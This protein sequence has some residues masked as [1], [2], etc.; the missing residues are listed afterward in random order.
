MSNSL[1][2]SF[3]LPTYNASATL[4]YTA[5]IF[6]ELTDILVSPGRRDPKSMLVT[7]HAGTANMTVD[8]SAGGA[9]VGGSTEGAQDASGMWPQGVYGA[10]L[11][12]PCTVIIPAAPGTG[13][14]VDG[15]YLQ[16]AD[17]TETGSGN[18]EAII[19]V[20][21]PLTTLP[22]SS[23]LLAMVSVSAGTTQ[24][25]NSAIAPQTNYAASPTSHLVGEI[26]MKAGVSIPTGFLACDG[27][28]V[29]RSSFPA[30]FSEIGI[31][32]GIGDGTT[33]FNLPNLNSSFMFPLGSITPGVQGGASAHTH[34]GPSHV[35]QLNGT[36]YALVTVNA[37]GGPQIQI[38]RKS[39]VSWV[40]NEGDS[41]ATA[42]SAGATGQTTGAD[43]GGQTSAD[44][45]E[46]TGST[47]NYPPWLTVFYVIKY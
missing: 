15:V 2:Q 17:K 36:G 8:I 11:A 3:D 10:R 37:G 43:L 22:A 26:I 6:R 20:Q 47:S 42:T 30:L 4:N 7:Q 14:R 12:S 41:S 45:A 35:H 44:G 32:Y 9:I 13:T 21:S 39:G 5:K 25:L 40:A 16:I 23:L 38:S 19:A 33:T 18:D 28:A 46:A 29:L 27:S 24:V 34:T 31:G 1:G